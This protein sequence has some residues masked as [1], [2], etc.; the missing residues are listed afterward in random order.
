M[1]TKKVLSPDGLTFLFCEVLFCIFKQ[2]LHRF[3]EFFFWADISGLCHVRTKLVSKLFIPVCLSCCLTVIIQSPV[4]GANTE[5]GQEV[6]KYFASGFDWYDRG[7]NLIPNISGL[8]INN[9][10]RENTFKLF[11]NNLFEFFG[12]AEVA[13]PEINTETTQYTK[14]ADEELD[15]QRRERD[16]QIDEFCHNLFWAVIIGAITGALI[17]LR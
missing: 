5:K 6:F 12:G 9:N 2:L 4:E 1:K 3:S 11:V 15:R 10:F 13:T 14:Q 8:D 7:S 16:K 17:P